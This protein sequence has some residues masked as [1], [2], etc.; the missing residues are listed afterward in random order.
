MPPV[1]RPAATKQRDGLH[2]ARVQAQAAGMARNA[3]GGA[4]LSSRL[5]RLEGLVAAGRLTA[6]EA[7]GARV[8]VR[9]K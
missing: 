7:A 5:A 2:H 4:A 6:E 3:P 8:K 1:S 9:Q